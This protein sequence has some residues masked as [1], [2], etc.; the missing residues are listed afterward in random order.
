M[1]KVITGESAKEY[2]GI[3][4]PESGKTPEE[5][6]NYAKEIAKESKNKDICIIT[7][8]AMLVE[9]LDCWTQWFETNASFYLDEKDCG[10]NLYILY[11]Y[12]GKP[13]DDINVLLLRLDRGQK[14][15]NY[16]V[17]CCCNCG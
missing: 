1:L 4:Y 6:F 5:L 11:D 7:Y 10:E 17:K 2:T 13:Y 9:A 16:N 14:E 15:S 12:L 8:S 3:M